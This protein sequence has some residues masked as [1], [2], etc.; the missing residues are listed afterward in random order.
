MPTPPSRD[1]PGRSVGS[2]RA[3]SQPTGQGGRSV[4]SFGAP[5]A[6][7]GTPISSRL[8]N[9]NPR[10]APSLLARV[11]ALNRASRR[12]QTCTV[13]DRTR[14]QLRTI[15][16]VVETLDAVDVRAWLFGGWGLDARIGRITREHGDIEF[17]LD[18]RDAERSQTAL[19]GAGA[20]ILM[21]QPP[22]E[23][24]E[25]TWDG[26]GFSTAYFDRQLDGAFSLQGRWSDW[27]FPPGS[28]GEDG[29]VLDGAP[30]PVMSAAGMLA[31]KEQYP[32]LRNGGAWRPRD[33][34]DI[35]VLRALVAGET[36]Q[37]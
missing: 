12:G 4:A 17:W 2:A 21:T 19:S 30:I 3:G 28:F 20:N 8:A 36:A 26:V 11:A 37:Q 31:M 34:H 29:G 1:R 9:G 15:L 22:E 14:A 10:W 18:R 24:C 32:R 5:P 33:I 35:D 23:S 27:I 6:W 25:F 7:R 16:A 13:D